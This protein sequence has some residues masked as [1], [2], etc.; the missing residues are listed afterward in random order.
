M[1]E[2]LL[3]SEMTLRIEAYEGRVVQRKVQP[4]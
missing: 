1:R 2:L 4:S 3:V